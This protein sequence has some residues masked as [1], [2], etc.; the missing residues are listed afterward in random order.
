[1]AI[2]VAMTHWV[3]SVPGQRVVTNAAAC[4]TRCK[5]AIQA[6]SFT[7]ACAADDAA[8]FRSRQIGLSIGTSLAARGLSAITVLISVPLT[9]NYLGAER[10]G[11]WAVIASISALLSFTDFGIGNNVITGTAILQGQSRYEELRRLIAHSMVALLGLGVLIVV[12]FAVATPFIDLVDLFNLRNT[13]YASEAWQTSWLVVACIAVAGPARLGMKV[14]TGLQEAWLVNIIGFFGS[15]SSLVSM[16]L[17]ARFQ[18]GLPILVLSLIFVP[19]FIDSLA[20]VI[21]FSLRPRLRPDFSS[22]DKR[23]LSAVTGAGSGFLIL[24]LSNAVLTQA[25]GLI[26]ARVMD[27]SAVS[28]FVIPERLFNVAGILPAL[29]LAPLWP[30]YGDAFARRDYAWIKKVFFSSVF[31]IT[32]ICLAC[33]TPIVLFNR[34][35]MNLWL[36]NFNNVPLDLLIGFSIWKILE[37]VGMCISILINGHGKLKSQIFAA[38]SVCIISIPLRIFLIKQI[39]VQ[40]AIWGLIFPYLFIAIPVTLFTALN[41]IS[42]QRDGVECL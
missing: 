25:N 24:Q 18:A 4:L 30:A 34:E 15:I 27:A 9:L 29:L 13:E 33:C 19:L 7:K 35:I 11:L 41:I 17:A 20:S 6:I 3:R 1:M 38:I 23:S 8:A 31:S 5:A 14:L 16:I 28:E 2:G 32:I 37:G 21:L 42:R 12:L 26:I 40:G 22:V 39:G 10:F 36:V